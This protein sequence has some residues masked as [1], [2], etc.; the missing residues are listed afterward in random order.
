VAIAAVNV[1]LN[2][3]AELRVSFTAHQ[4]VS[5]T[6]VRQ[7][8]VRVTLTA[9]SR[10]LPWSSAKTGQTAER[11]S[12]RRAEAE[13]PAASPARERAQRSALTGS[14]RPGVRDGLADRAGLAGSFTGVA[15]M[16]RRRTSRHD[17]PSLTSAGMPM[18]IAVVTS[19]A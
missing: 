4:A 16:A 1:T 14:R 17:M 19:T 8:P 9:E 11:G 2:A 10:P 13:A 18:M 7:A 5:V 6:F 3:S 12:A 15:C